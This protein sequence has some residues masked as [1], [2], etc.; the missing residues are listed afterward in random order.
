[1]KYFRIKPEVAGGWGS[2]TKFTRVAGERRIIHDFDYEFDDWAGDDILTSVGCYIVTERLAADIKQ[3]ALSG[4]VF[5]HVTISHSGIF[6]D[7]H[8][9]GLDLPSFLWMKVEGAATQGD[10]GRDDGYGLVVS[11]RALLVLQA[12]GQLLHAGIEP[13]DGPAR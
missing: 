11:E 10:F 12:S 4:I 8:P 1:M 2:G 5:D 3:A 6:E 9:D 13:Y 7:L